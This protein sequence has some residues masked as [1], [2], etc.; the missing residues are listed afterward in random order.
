MS[1]KWPRSRPVLRAGT[2]GLAARKLGRFYQGIDLRRDYHDI[3]LRRL[4]ES[5]SAG[6]DLPE[7]A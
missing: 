4:A 1:R 7:A 3:A 2:T 5:Q 6:T